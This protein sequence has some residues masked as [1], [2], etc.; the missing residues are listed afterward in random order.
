MVDI[1][2]AVMY[3]TES[4]DALKTLAIGG[5]LLLLSFLVVPAVLA[6]GYIVSVVRARYDGQTTPPS[7]G[8]WE[9]LFVDGLKAMVIGFVYMLVPVVV[10]FVTVGGAMLAL[11]TGSRAGG[12]AAVGSLVTGLLLTVVLGLVFGYLAVAAVLNFVHEGSLAAGFDVGR[13]TTLATSGDY[14]VAWAAT[15]GVS[16]VLSIISGALNFV[17]I[18]GS[19]AAVFV[20]FY[21][22]VVMAHLWADGYID[23]FELESRSATRSVADTR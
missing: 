23:T 19:I 18:L 9:T 13:I 21:G 17:P 14:L 2:A 7:F 22:Q 8:D 4:D 12:A 5:V 16:I 1:E 3:P 6:Y 10:A 11:L 20:G 15:I